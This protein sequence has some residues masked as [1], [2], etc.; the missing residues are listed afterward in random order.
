MLGR[1]FKLGIIGG[2]IAGSY[3]TYLASRRGINVEVFE[4]T[5]KRAWS[6]DPL[7]TRR[8]G[9]G[10]W[11]KKLED[12]GI[13]LS[14]NSLPG[15]VENFTKTLFLGR[16]HQNKLDILKARIDPYLFLNR[17]AFETYFYKKVTKIGAIWHF[18]ENVENFQRWQKK[19]NFNLIFGAWGANPNLTIQ[20]VDNSYKQEFVLACQY[21]L[22]GFDSSKI[23][24]AKTLVL[25]DD[26]LV[27]YFYIFPKGDLAEANVGMCFNEL[28][29]KM[30]FSQLDQF[31]K[32]DPF[33][34]FKKAKV[35]QERSFAKTLCAGL[36][37]KRENLLVE[38]LLLGGDAGFTTDPVSGG[39]MGFALLAAKKAIDSCFSQNPQKEFYGEL[40]PLTQSL[41]R[42]YQISKKL[43]PKTDKEKRK[44]NDQFFTAAK[45]VIKSGGVLSLGK[46]A[47]EI[48][49]N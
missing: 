6:T 29:V 31:L 49:V 10:V 32:L 41:E 13:E 1:C 23:K 11:K 46:I 28:N 34:M 26:P 36:P 12:A 43:Y 25:T 30:P 8:C 18:G 2:G 5:P 40:E 48:L 17:Q 39:G 9:E 42:S 24:N 35:V 44:V 33:R 20:V 14:L 22:S 47:E 3:A 4:K 27:R 7:A 16:L 37:I 38:S 19:N 15:Y 21:T 45:E